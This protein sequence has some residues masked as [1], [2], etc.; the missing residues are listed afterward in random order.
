[1]SCCLLDSDRC[2][3]GSSPG[4]DESHSHH[5]HVASPVAGLLPDAWQ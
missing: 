5:H 1:L 2:R 4:Q 3:P